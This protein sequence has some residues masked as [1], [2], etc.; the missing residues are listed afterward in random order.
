[1]INYDRKLRIYLLLFAVLWGSYNPVMAQK[2]SMEL[3]ISLYSDDG[4]GFVII[5]HRGAS[6]Y[7]PMLLMKWEQK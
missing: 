2:N 7:H 5:A 3:P 6:A 1:M 4:D